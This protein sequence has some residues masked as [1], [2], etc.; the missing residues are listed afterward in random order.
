MEYETITFEGTEE[1]FEAALQEFAERNGCKLM[2]N[3][4][5]TF[6]ILSPDGGQL[7]TGVVDKEGTP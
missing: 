4:D 3:E 1:E 6:T 7:T 2:A 5:G